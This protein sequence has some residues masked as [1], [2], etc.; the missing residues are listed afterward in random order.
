YE[1][2][3]ERYYNGRD[4]RREQELHEENQKTRKSKK[5]LIAIIVILLIIVA[6]FVTRAVLN[7]NNDKVS[8]DPDVSQNYKKEVES[9]NDDINNK[10]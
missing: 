4:Y 8:N 5:W 10:V 7:H 6:I 3:P 1:Q 9:Q 2:N